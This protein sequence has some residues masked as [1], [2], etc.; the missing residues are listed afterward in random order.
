MTPVKGSFNPQKVETHRLRTDVEVRESAQEL[1]ILDGM[2]VVLFL[3]QQLILVSVSTEL[4][5]LTFYFYY[6]DYLII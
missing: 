3:L 5:V 6:L 4:S 1:L 2:S